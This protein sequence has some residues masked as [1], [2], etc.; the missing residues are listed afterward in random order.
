MKICPKCKQEKPLNKF[1]KDKS[2][3]TG[4]RSWCKKCTNESS[5]NYIRG[6]SKEKRQL[7]H[8]RK[9]LKRSY[10]I[11]PEEY[12]QRLEEQNSCC[13]ICGERNN[14]L[15]MNLAVDHDHQTG[16]IRG[17][18]CANCNVI[19]GMAKDNIDILAS[20]ISY[21]RNV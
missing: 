8:Q 16:Q 3:T 17:L 1:H 7:F 13:S 18:L 15:S 5:K 2:T 14:N 11:T 6:M 12:T 20:T 9:N 21:L 10:N 19:L 4:L